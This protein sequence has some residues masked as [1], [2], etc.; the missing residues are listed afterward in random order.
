[1]SVSLSVRPSAHPH[2]KTRLPIDGIHEIWYLSIFG[3]YA[4]K[5]QILSKSYKNNGYFTWRPKYVFDHI[6][7]NSY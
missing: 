7:L 4:E 6:S 1:M 3:K 5:I 2:G